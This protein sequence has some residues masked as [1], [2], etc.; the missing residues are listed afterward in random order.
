[1]GQGIIASRVDHRRDWVKLIGVPLGEVMLS[2][3]SED[4]N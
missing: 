1:M 2:Q 4:V 3:R